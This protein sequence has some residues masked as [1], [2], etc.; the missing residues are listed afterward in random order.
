MFLSQFTNALWPFEIQFHGSPNRHVWAMRSLESS[1]PCSRPCWIGLLCHAENKSQ[2]VAMAYVLH[3][4]F[5]WLPQTP[6][7]LTLARRNYWQ[8]NLSITVK[9]ARW[10]NSYSWIRVP[11]VVSPRPL[12]LICMADTRR[13]EPTICSIQNP[14]KYDYLFVDDTFGTGEIEPSVV[15]GASTD[16]SMVHSR[17]H[18]GYSALTVDSGW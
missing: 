6:S 16:H 15:R 4:R 7:S 13:D 17:F 5:L 1:R 18:W 2:S 11:K 12:I 9:E 8:V 14:P 10:V 3:H